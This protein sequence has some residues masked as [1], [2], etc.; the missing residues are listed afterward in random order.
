MLD[1]S[2][3]LYIPTVLEPDVLEGHPGPDPDPPSNT[4]PEDMEVVD[5]AE[6]I[7]VPEIEGESVVT[8][9]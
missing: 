6:I 2:E 5:E 8:E 1:N 4:T 7:E 3:V 9:L